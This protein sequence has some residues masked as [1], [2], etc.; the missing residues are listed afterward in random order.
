[1]WAK[2][3]VPAFYP[4]IIKEEAVKKVSFD[5]AVKASAGGEEVVKFSWPWFIAFMYATNMRVKPSRAEKLGWKRQQQ[6]GAE[7]SYFENLRTY[8]AL[9]EASEE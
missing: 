8:L 3:V 9:T 1:M 7:I 4:E 6:N 5:E 2:S